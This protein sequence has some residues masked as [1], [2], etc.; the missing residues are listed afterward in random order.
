M[1]AAGVEAVVDSRALAVAGL[2]EVVLHIPRIHGEFRKLVREARRHPPD[3]AVLT[4]SPDFHLR[5]AK[6]LLPLNVPVV[7]LVAP[8]VWAW[9]KG[10]L[11]LMRRVITRLLCIFPFE[12]AFFEKHRIPARYIGHP[13][14]RLVRPSGSRHELRIRFAA[15]EERPL[16]VLLPGS[17]PGEI[18]RHLPAVLD[19]VDEIRKSC[20]CLFALSLPPGFASRADL[21]HFEER[22]RRSSIQVFEGKTW[23]LL[24][25]AELALAASGTVTVEAT[26]LGTP[27]VTFY[28]VTGL[29]WILGKLLVRTPFYSMVNLLA[30]RAIVPE[31]L[32]SRMTGERIA[33]DAVR[34]LKEPE[35]RERM[36]ED[37]AQVAGQLAAAGDPMET[38]AAAV[39]QVI[40]RCSKQTVKEEAHA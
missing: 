13:L 29:S 33:A 18:R 23:D 24:A 38:A 11:P 26:L 31:L 27:M 28:R 37:L 6:K 2:V 21:Q 5:L 30:G 14:A 12:E 1:Q 9:R 7:Y 17:R 25:C 10:R 32:Q 39:E 15:P 34:L 16:V 4:D 22:F 8:Q 35:L 19:A 20:D 36:K 40:E 3:V